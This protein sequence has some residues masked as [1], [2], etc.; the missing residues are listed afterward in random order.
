[1]E[2]THRFSYLQLWAEI[3]IAIAAVFGL[4]FSVYQNMQLAGILDDAQRAFK[5]VGYPVVQ[6]EDM[7]WYAGPSTDFCVQPP[8]GANLYFRNRSNSPIVLTSTNVDYFLG[9]RPLKKT[10]MNVGTGG[11]RI[12]TPG[13]ITG[14]GVQTEDFGKTYLKTSGQLNQPYLNAKFELIY[15]SIISPEQQFRYTG[16][17]VFLHDCRLPN[18]KQ[19]SIGEEKIEP[20]SAH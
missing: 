19:Y 11:D 16:R 10:E 9:D 6:F 18:Q 12:L 13:T 8:H 3:V 14:F 20:I 1:M 7:Q 2:K 15:H 4:G 17:I 5:V